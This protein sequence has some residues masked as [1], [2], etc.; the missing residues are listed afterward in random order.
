MKPEL[1]SWDVRKTK[2]GRMGLGKQGGVS[3][4]GGESV[5]RGLVQCP[6]HCGSKILQERGSHCQELEGK[7]DQSK[8]QVRIVQGVRQTLVPRTGSSFRKHLWK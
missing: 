1:Q 7:L 2:M 5:S 6:G 4:G 8:S 3:A